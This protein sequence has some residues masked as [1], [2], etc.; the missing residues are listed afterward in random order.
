M[1]SHGTL[2]WITKTASS[3]RPPKFIPQWSLPVHCCRCRPTIQTTNTTIFPPIKIP[4]ILFCGITLETPSNRHTC[5]SPWVHSHSGPSSSGI[6]E[7]L[8]PSS[9]EYL[10]IGL[11]PSFKV[12]LLLGHQV[13]HYTLLIWVPPGRSPIPAGSIP[14][15]K[16]YQECSGLLQVQ[17]LHPQYMSILFM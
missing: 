8:M 5:P 7:Y 15:T 6:M 9:S 1:C 2:I 14:N 3:S 13:F 10:S 16:F 17:I 12:F 4:R 11:P